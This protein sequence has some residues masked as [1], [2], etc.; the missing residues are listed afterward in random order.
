MKNNK[1]HCEPSWATTKVSGDD[2]TAIQR[3]AWSDQLYHTT[4]NHNYLGGHRKAYLD[5]P[6]SFQ[7]MQMS[8]S[9]S[10]QAS[11]GWSLLDGGVRCN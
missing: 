5:V 3:G 10:Q 1:S 11:Y 4:I 2:D 9:L 8:Y 7:L 6:M